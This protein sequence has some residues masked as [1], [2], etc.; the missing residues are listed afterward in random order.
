M[1]PEDA[2]EATVELKTFYPSGH[3]FD[4]VLLCG[5]WVHC[6]LGTSWSSYPAS[7]VKEITWRDGFPRGA[8]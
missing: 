6:R 5:A 4:G 8:I 7:D 3:D 2:Q 1:N